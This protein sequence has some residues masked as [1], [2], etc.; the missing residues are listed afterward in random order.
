MTAT[1]PPMG[2][3]WPQR[4]ALG[5]GSSGGAVLPMLQDRVPWAPAC[6][7]PGGPTVRATPPVD[8]EARVAALHRLGVLDQ[9]P[10]PDLEALTRLACYVTGAPASVVNLIDT[11]RQWQAA[12]TGMVCAPSSRE[13]SMCAH[14]VAADALVH[15]PDARLDQRFADNPFVVGPR[16]LNRLYAAVPLHDH[17]GHAV[18]TLCVVDPRAR[19]LADGQLGALRDLAAQ[20]EHLLEMRRQHAALLDV[21]TEVDHYATHDAL[22]GLVNRR[23]LYDRLAQALARA[24]RS[25]VAPTVFYCDVDGFKAVNDTHG[26]GVG[27]Q[28]LVAVAAAVRSVVRPQDTVARLGGDEFVVV[29]EELPEHLVG[30]VAER[31]RRSMRTHPGTPAAAAG[32]GLSVGVLTAR[33]PATPAEVLCDADRLMYAE[34]PARSRAR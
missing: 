11:D 8:D 10:A 18:G 1:A 31:I 15:V 12:A 16:A 6:T 27:D 24:E 29:C 13:D 22:T 32:L 25:G 28:V 7:R 33:V 30:A 3:S 26:H 21:L 19:A 17:S 2:A 34:K 20:A 5:R 4:C 14:T 23:V 9:P